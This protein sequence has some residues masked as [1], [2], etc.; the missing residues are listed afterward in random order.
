MSNWA[1]F[2]LFQYQQHLT[3]FTFGKKTSRSP[4]LAFVNQMKNRLLQL[5]NVLK[6]TNKPSVFAGNLLAGLLLGTFAALFVFNLPFLNI[7]DLPPLPLFAI[8]AAIALVF[9]YIFFY[10]REKYPILYGSFEVAIATVIAGS[11]VIATKGINWVIILPALYIA[12]RGLDNINKD[13]K[14]R[15]SFS[16]CGK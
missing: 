11:S 13:L 4:K 15:C 3:Q 8:G 2:N 16:I 14:A 6:Q 9:G 1:A 7:T 5:L 10:I 12:V